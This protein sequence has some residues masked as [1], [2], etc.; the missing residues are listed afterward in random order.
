MPAFIRLARLWFPRR[1]SGSYK[2]IIRLP[3]S[4]PNG[5]FKSSSLTAT[6]GP[7]R[8]EGDLQRDFCDYP[9]SLFA[10]FANSNHQCRPRSRI[11]GKRFQMFTLGQP[12]TLAGPEDDRDGGALCSIFCGIFHKG[13]ASDGQRPFGPFP[14]NELSF[15]P[16]ARLLFP[17]CGPFP[18]LLL[19]G[20]QNHQR[21]G[22][23]SG[24]FD[25]YWIFCPKYW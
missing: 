5:C 14:T 22:R 4:A 21:N 25:I 16:G 12:W 23:I 18:E 10:F 24:S 13:S 15:C 2:S 17:G 19:C 9:S 20:L 11:Y 7:A 8:Q 3:R 6:N 1:W